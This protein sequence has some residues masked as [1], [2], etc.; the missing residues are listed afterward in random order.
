VK[1]SVKV[2]YACRVLA[3]LARHYGSQ[4][5]A[6]IEALAKAEEIS[7]NY[8]AQIL[9]DLRNGGLIISRRGKFGGYA[10]AHRPEAITLYDIV[11]VIDP[12]L[13]EFQVGQEGASGKRVSEVWAEVQAQF[14]KALKEHTLESLAE[15]RGEEMYHI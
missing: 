3:Q 12:E 7:P 10:L 9:G 15:D 8:L 2:E 5:L 6:H 14:V 1:L 13:I 11:Y 4:E